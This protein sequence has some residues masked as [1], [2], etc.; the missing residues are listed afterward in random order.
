M[1]DLRV[2]H[3]E[4]QSPDASK[5]PPRQAN[6]LT[7][8]TGPDRASAGSGDPRTP[9]V[10]TRG[11][12]TAATRRRTNRRL[13]AF[14]VL[15]LAAV[16][17]LLFKGIGTSLNYYV[18]VHQALSERTSL[19]G[20]TFRLRGIVAPHSVSHHGDIVDFTVEQSG[21]HI[22]VVNQ[23]SPPQLFQVG[24]P[25]IVQGHF[26]GLTFYSHQV[27]VDHTGNYSPERDSVKTTASARKR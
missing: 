3:D 19:A 23:G 11:P 15:L 8:A 13:A 4:D 2:D 12:V 7:P 14:G 20:K 6:W 17:F 22:A 16:G 5:A 26:D 9:S 18:T 21:Q 1:T 25:V 27:I 24:I 10:K